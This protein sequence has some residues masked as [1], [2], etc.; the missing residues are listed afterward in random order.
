[1]DPENS[2]LRLVKRFPYVTAFWLL[3]AGLSVSG[4]ASPML[5]TLLFVAGAGTLAYQLREYISG[6]R[7]LD[8]WDQG[9]LIVHARAVSEWLLPGDAIEKFGDASLFGKYIAIREAKDKKQ[10]EITALRNQLETFRMSGDPSASITFSLSTMEKQDQIRRL[11][12][13]MAAKEA[14]DHAQEY[15]W[16]RVVEDFHVQLANGK[17]LAKGLPLRD[18]VAHR[19]RHIPS[20]QWRV[21]RVDLGDGV[22]QGHG[23]HYVGVVIGRPKARS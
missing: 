3:A 4:L 17:L 14:L 2:P 23:L 15:A 5:A 7:I 10:N 21:L 8:L 18:S 22:A 6:A 12:E 19:E 11:A 9:L 20:Y 13:A 1:M 16:E